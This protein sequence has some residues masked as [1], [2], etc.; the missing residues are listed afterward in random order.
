MTARTQLRVLHAVL[1][2]RRV[3][4]SACAA[5]QPLAA[6]ADAAAASSPATSA[7]PRP[8]RPLP[9]GRDPV[10]AHIGALARRFRVDPHLFSGAPPWPREGR[11]V[12]SHHVSC[13]AGVW[14]TR[15]RA[16]QC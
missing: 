16:A 4:S 6:A 10:D 12:R 7:P 11:R 3:A 13:A 15:A 2:L 1:Q 9:P 5:Q 14:L 8:R